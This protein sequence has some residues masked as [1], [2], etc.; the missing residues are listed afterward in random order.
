MPM[1]V[2]TLE[3]VSQA[4]VHKGA[5]KKQQQQQQQQQQQPQQYI[6]YRHFG[7]SMAEP[8]FADSF[9]KL[10]RLKCLS[11]A[12]GVGDVQI[13]QWPAIS[14]VD[15]V[16]CFHAC[17]RAGQSPP[18]YFFRWWMGGYTWGIHKVVI[19]DFLLEQGWTMLELS[20]VVWP[21]MEHAEESQSE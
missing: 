18:G 15:A 13:E 2:G 14:I 1:T 9:S 4:L 3:A 6:T 20:V 17:G 11:N 16:P 7:T 19:N 10:L 5:C 21:P 12:S 8:T